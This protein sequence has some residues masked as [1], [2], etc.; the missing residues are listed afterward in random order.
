MIC[1]APPV[2]TWR[3]LKP[4]CV[5][6][7]TLTSGMR[8]PAVSLP[9]TSRAD[10]THGYGGPNG[11]GRVPADPAVGVGTEV[12]RPHHRQLGRVRQRERRDR[13]QLLQRVVA[14]D[15]GVI[16]PAGHGR[17]RRA[18]AVADPAHEVHEGAAVQRRVVDHVEGVRP[19]RAARA[20]IGQLR[21]PRGVLRGGVQVATHERR[22]VDVR[23]RR[24][25]ACGRGRRHPASTPAAV[26]TK[27]SFGGSPFGGDPL[28][29]TVAASGARVVLRSVGEGEPVPEARCRLHRR[30][31]AAMVELAAA[32][33]AHQ[34]QRPVDGP[35]TGL[36][37]VE[38]RGTADAG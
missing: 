24:P 20:A 8:T 23:T 14:E 36:V 1:P 16:G 6:T 17:R 12:E 9:S 22:V 38:A 18:H 19:S 21:Q 35:R 25:R 26:S 10:T 29:Q 37:D 4:R 7:G 33:A 31:R 11:L 32:A 28:E 15:G 27:I 34:A 3:G 30:L 13:G 5:A 2:S